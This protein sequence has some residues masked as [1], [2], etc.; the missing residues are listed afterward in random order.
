MT[1]VSDK[2]GRQY[3]EQMIKQ[4]QFYLVPDHLHRRL[5]PVSHLTPCRV[6][7]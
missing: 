3:E 4:K 2:G 1:A 5:S 6:S 7:L